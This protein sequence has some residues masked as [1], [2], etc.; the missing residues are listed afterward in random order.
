MG[1]AER[2]M[3]TFRMLLLYE[4]IE[5]GFG[6]CQAFWEFSNIN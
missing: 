5:L 4:G 3:G 1:E 2:K 6:R